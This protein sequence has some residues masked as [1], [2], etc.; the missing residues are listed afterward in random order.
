MSIVKIHLIDSHDTAVIKYGYLKGRRN[1]MDIDLW[2]AYTDTKQNGTADEKLAYMF[3]CSEM[4][5]DVVLCRDARY[6]LGRAFLYGEGIRKDRA[7]AMEL[8]K[9]SADMGNFKAME[10]VGQLL[11]E[12]GLAE[13][14]N[15][16][17]KQAKETK[18]PD[19]ELDAIARNIARLMRNRM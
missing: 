17:L 9:S 13:E 5:D 16:Y 11:I 10:L 12:D 1:G 6:D 2:K 19:E 7:Q 18:L 8:L 14:G 15:A 3:E 4:E